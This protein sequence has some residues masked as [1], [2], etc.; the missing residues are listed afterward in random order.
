VYRNISLKDL[1]G[2]WVPKSTGDIKCLPKLKEFA[3]TVGESNNFY[4][5]AYSKDGSE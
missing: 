5:D 3:N 1:K 4:D 2:T